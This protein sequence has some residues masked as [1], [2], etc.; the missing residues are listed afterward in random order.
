LGYFPFSKAGAELLFEVI[1]AAYK[2][3]S[4]MLTTNLAFGEW[5]EIFGSERLTG[6]LLDRLTRRH[7][8]LQANGESY[9]FRQ[10]RKRSNWRL[11]S[12]QDS[13]PK[14]KDK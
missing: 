5:T 10:A 13:N 14:E 2:Y 11:S 7:H 8:I 4:L 3:H 1:S 12:R 6:A 9:Q